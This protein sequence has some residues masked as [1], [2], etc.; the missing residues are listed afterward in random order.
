MLLKENNGPFQSHAAHNAC[1]AIYDNMSTKRCCQQH[2]MGWIHHSFISLHFIVLF[3]FFFFLLDD[4]TITWIVI[5]EYDRT[6]GYFRLIFGWGYVSKKL[7]FFN[8]VLCMLASDGLRVSE[9]F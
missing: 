8:F 1:T 5:G 3:L 9:G 6:L 7:S 2:H 4:L